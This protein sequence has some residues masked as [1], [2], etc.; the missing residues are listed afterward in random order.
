ME[1]ILKLLI[2]QLEN[3][4]LSLE[5]LQDKYFDHQQTKDKVMEEMNR[6]PKYNNFL[7]MEKLLLN[8]RYEVAKMIAAIH[9]LKKKAESMIDDLKKEIKNLPQ[10]DQPYK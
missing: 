3:E 1:N 5:N 8:N 10:D 7:Q 6:R 4:N 2:Q 9:N